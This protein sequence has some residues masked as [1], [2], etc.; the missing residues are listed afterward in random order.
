MQ[1][2]VNGLAQSLQDLLSS[3]LASQARRGDTL[4]L[5]TFN[6]E[7]S[8]GQFPLQHWS[9]E[10]QKSITDHLVEF[11][12]AQKFEKGTRFDRVIPAVDRLVKNSPFLTIIL[13][14]A[15]DDEIHGTAFDQRINN[16]FQ[17][18]RAQQQESG[19]PFVIAL[20]AQGGHLVE[21]SMNPSPWPTELPALPKELFVPLPPPAPLAHSAKT[22]TVP[23][24][25][26]SG[27]KKELAT[28]ATTNSLDS[29][30]HAANSLLVQPSSPPVIGASTDASTNRV[31]SIAESANSNAAT[32]GLPAGPSTASSS[33]VSVAGQT[34]AI[35]SA[36]QAR[37]P[38][39]NELVHASQGTVST[40]P[41]EKAIPGATANTAISSSETN[42]SVPENR[43]QENPPVDSIE[44]AATSPSRIGSPALKWGLGAGAFVF[45]A[46]AVWLWRRRARPGTETS[47]ITES[48][49][50]RKT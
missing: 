49:D 24:L 5:W 13:V 34:G 31:Q 38:A 43:A 2:R 23:P 19:R 41:G 47:L 48:I 14:C 25:I 7:L 37:A 28:P 1:K 50:R 6:E 33:H 20:R 11:V 10:S 16:F 15:G 22:S 35:S 21:C 39:P 42:S 26:V 45:T 29:K 17:T 46:L 44:L 32:A 40:E 3:G 27:R 12:K 30:S 9:A 36:E 18:S 4:G 8:A